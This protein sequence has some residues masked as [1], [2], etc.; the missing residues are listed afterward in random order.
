MELNI[1]H[2][3]QVEGKHLLHLSSKKQIFLQELVFSCD[4]SA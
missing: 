3:S 2:T 4:L 1:M